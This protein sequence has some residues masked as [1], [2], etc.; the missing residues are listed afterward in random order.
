M[1]GCHLIKAHQHELINQRV[2]AAISK[3]TDDIV[4]MFTERG[5]TDE[6]LRAEVLGIIMRHA[7]YGD[8][9]TN[10]AI[11][12]TDLESIREFAHA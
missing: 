11:S 9:L 3:A 5:C 4:E 1:G 10:G 8:A 6:S 2:E 12:D 7:Y